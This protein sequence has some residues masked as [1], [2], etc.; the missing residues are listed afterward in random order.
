MRGAAEAQR[1][2]ARAPVSA[3]AR[4]A[5][6]SSACDSA[7]H[8]THS[9]S[10][11]MRTPARQDVCCAHNDA[12]RACSHAPV[13]VQVERLVVARLAADVCV[14]RRGVSVEALRCE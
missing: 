1:C 5:G 11:Q 10:R 12:V 13:G 3:A 2:S 7:R 14:F 9:L 4:A 8:T 6:C